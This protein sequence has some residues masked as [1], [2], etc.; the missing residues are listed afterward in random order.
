[1]TGLG[2]MVLV[3]GL[4]TTTRWAEQTARVNAEQ[5]GG[6]VVAPAPAR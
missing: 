3:L 5:L 4:T 6:D 1:V 2:V